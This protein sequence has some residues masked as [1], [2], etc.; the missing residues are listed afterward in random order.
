MYFKPLFIK[1][2]IPLAYVISLQY[3]T[4]TQYFQLPAVSDIQA[5]EHRNECFD[6]NFLS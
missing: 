2:E 5:F 6:V 1:I 3:C 4:H